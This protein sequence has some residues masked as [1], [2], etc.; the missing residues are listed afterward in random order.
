M[1]QIHSL[2]KYWL[3]VLSSRTRMWATKKAIKIQVLQIQLFRSHFFL[4]PVQNNYRTVLLA[5]QSCDAVLSQAYRSLTL[6]SNSFS[7]TKLRRLLIFRLLVVYVITSLV[8]AI[9]L[10]PKQVFIDFSAAY[11]SPFYSGL[12]I[13]FHRCC[14]FAATRHTFQ[15]SY[16]IT[17]LLCQSVFLTRHIYFTIN[18]RRLRLCTS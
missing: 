6:L 16:S 3:F 15:Q 2:A 4:K 8:W 5:L 13:V 17:K 18:C 1:E 9:S 10:P 11:L 14:K 12:S 7:S